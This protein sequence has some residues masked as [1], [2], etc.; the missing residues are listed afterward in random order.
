MALVVTDDAGH[1][2][3]SEWTLRVLDANPPTEIPRLFS[4][5]IEIEYD[6]KPHE[7]DELELNLS[8]SYD[9]LDSIGYDSWSVWVEED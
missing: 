3:L 5:G 1:T 8:H 6:D 7:K 4:N 9:E 2:V